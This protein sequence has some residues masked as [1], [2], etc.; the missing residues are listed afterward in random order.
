MNNL[1]IN[2]NNSFKKKLPKYNNAGFLAEAGVEGSEAS[3]LVGGIASTAQFAGGM[4]GDMDEAFNDGG[5]SWG[6]GISGALK[7]AG[8]GA[9]AGLALAPFT[10]GLSVPIGAAIGAI[11]GGVLGAK[12]GDNAQSGRRDYD[13][14]QDDKIRDFK[15]QQI[16][17]GNIINPDLQFAY[18][19]Q[20]QGQG[21]GQGIQGSQ[22][23]RV[24]QH[25]QQIQQRIQ[26]GQMQQQQAQQQQ[27][28][29]EMQQQQGNGIGKNPPELQQNNNNTVIND[30]QGQS[31]EGPQEGIPVD[32]QGN[33]S[34][35]SNNEP[36]ALVEDNEVSW[37]DADGKTYIFSDKLS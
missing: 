2:Y 30:Y 3:G 21:I 23:P 5:T 16:R 34:I 17:Q 35:K 22:N 7:G 15:T 37:K 4:T 10:A 28:Q 36:V 18:G 19:G 6:Q 25:M 32:A 24:Q 14:L 20:M 27:A 13:N 8:S 31:H 12:K 9:T 29:Q 26:Q 11:G 33:P 1:T